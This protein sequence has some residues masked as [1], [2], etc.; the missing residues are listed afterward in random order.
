[1][2][3]IE[4]NSNT[5][6]KIEDEVSSPPFLH[7]LRRW[8]DNLTLAPDG[9]SRHVYITGGDFE[10]TKTT[11]GWL[12]VM[13]WDNFRHNFDGTYVKDEW[14]EITPKP[15]RKIRLGRV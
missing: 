12:R 9:R 2:K 6:P 5:F 4:I 10:D 13:S 15:G 8:F 7:N 3:A 1:M 14:F 11:P